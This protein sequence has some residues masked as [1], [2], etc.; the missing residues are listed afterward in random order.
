LFDKKTFVL[1]VAV[2]WVLTLIT[3]FF[4]PNLM[5]LFAQISSEPP[6]A[7]F[8]YSPLER[9]VNSS[10]T[11]VA[12]ASYDPDGSIIKYSWDFGDGNKGTGMI[13]HHSY[14]QYGTYTVTLTVTDNDGAT[15]TAKAN[16]Q[17]D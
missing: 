17:L 16:I 5:H 6:V 12:S 11:F 7:T 3:V 4:A 8:T 14:P 1:A 9:Q 13:S 15:N 10:I 2:S